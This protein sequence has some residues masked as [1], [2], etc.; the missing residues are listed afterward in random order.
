MAECPQCGVKWRTR[1]VEEDQRLSC[2]FC[3]YEFT[4]HAMTKRTA[5]LS[6]P[7]FSQMEETDPMALQ[8]GAGLIGTE[9]P[10]HFRITLEIISGPQ[11]GHVL[12]IIESCMTIGR[13]FQGTELVDATISRKHAVIEIYG[14]RGILLRDLASINGT[15]VNGQ[16][17]AQAQLKNGDAVRMGATEFR[18]RVQ[19]K[20]T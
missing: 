6:R 10:S 17:I 3:G 14:N 12:E 8:G 9:L 19:P 2:P 5:V 7:D 13:C 4:F 11:K 1:G 15:H 18:L 20:P 16:L